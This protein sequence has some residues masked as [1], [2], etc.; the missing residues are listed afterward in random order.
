MHDTSLMVRSFPMPAQA[1]A[2]LPGPWQN[3]GSTLLGWI[4]Q[5]GQL[6]VIME[7]LPRHSLVHFRT[8]RV[9]AAPQHTTT[10]QLDA[11]YQA[12]RNA[13]NMQ[14]RRQ[15]LGN[16]AQAFMPLIRATIR[17]CQISQLADRADLEQEAF[18]GLHDALQSYDPRRSVTLA[19]FV[20]WRIV[21]AVLDARRK[22]TRQSRH[23]RAGDILDGGAANPALQMECVSLTPRV[24][25]EDMFTVLTRGLSAREIFVLRRVIL[26]DQTC[27]QIGQLMGLHHGRVGQIYR[28]AIA[29]LRDNPRARQLLAGGR[30]T[31]QVT[32]DRFNE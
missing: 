31:L 7:K 2:L 8:P 4:Q 5:R 6:P 12:W 24:E 20:R 28:G 15:A 9:S 32:A 27:R 11:M 14:T 18:M 25:F 23:S 19:G 1:V 3:L 10:D 21:G 16:L 26:E 13:Q 17:H 22:W 30:A 29:H